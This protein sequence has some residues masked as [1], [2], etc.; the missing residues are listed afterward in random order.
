MDSPLIVAYGGGTNSTAMLCGF[1][2]KSVRPALILF[3]DTGAELPRTYQH[4][5]LMSLKCLE[6]F[7]IPIETV[8]KT[9]KGERSTLEQDC[10][11][12]KSL[13]SL[14]VGFKA[15]S[16][17]YKIEPVNKRVRTWMDDN[18][19]KQVIKAIGYDAAEGHRS[20]KIKQT[21]LGAGRVELN[22]F[23]LLDWNWRRGECVDAVSR[24][25]LPQPGKSSCFYCPAMKV[26]EIIRL[27]QEHPE[28]YAR[29]L[30]MEE[31]MVVKGRVE[32]LAFGFFGFVNGRQRGR[33]EQT[34]VSRHRD[35]R[36]IVLVALV[37]TATRIVVNR[38]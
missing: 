26:R 10:L 19:H 15:C 12:N 37:M 34:T 3:S 6:W 29:A 38:R 30:A 23:P 24:H 21:D 14:A 1:R 31:N 7:G 9:Y 4:I 20:T 27:R 35:C 22:W 5:E 17:K 16:M 25:G 32:G 36:H 18:G 11:R 2:E 28:H 33:G 8:W 13:P